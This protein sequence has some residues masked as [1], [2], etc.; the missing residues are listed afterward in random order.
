[1]PDGVHL[2][3]KPGGFGG[4]STLVDLFEAGRT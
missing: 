4:P 3:T 1:M 2:V